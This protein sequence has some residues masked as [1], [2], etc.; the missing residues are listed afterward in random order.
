MSFSCLKYFSGP[1]QTVSKSQTSYHDFQ[2]SL[3]SNSRLSFMHLRSSCVQ[4]YIWCLLQFLF[5]CFIS[6]GL[7][8]GCCV[9]CSVAA[10]SGATRRWSA[11]SWRRP[12]CKAQP[13]GARALAQQLP[14][15][16]LG[17][18]AARGLLPDQGSNPCL[19]PRQA[20]SLPLSHREAPRL[21]PSGVQRRTPTNWLA[22]FSLRVPG[23]TCLSCPGAFAWLSFLDA[24]A[25]L[26]PYLTVCWSWPLQLSRHF[27][28]F[29]FFIAFNKISVSWCVCFLVHHHVLLPE[30]L[31]RLC[32]VL[33][34]SSV[35]KSEHNAESVFNIY[36]MPEWV[37]VRNLV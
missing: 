25:L 29:I 12:Y 10:E 21:M 14:W 4:H 3:P 20:D 13:P 15:Y 2:D 37:N 27:T 24:P 33:C 31:W 36:L 18:P 32:L 1:S 22:G 35:P 17:G 34:V 11:F 8:L 6:L 28:V 16:R 7:G 30:C 26:C 5:V 9:G 23:S 19:L